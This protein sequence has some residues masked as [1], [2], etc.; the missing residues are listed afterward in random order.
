VPEG[1]HPVPEA[2]PAPGP[3]VDPVEGIVLPALLRAMADP[4]GEVRSAA[5]V[6]LG[7]IGSARAY[8]VLRAALTDAHPDVRD[9]AVLAMGLL[10]DEFGLDDFAGLLLDPAVRGRTRGFA[11]LAAGICGGDASADLLLRF[12]A[13]QSDSL[14]MGG[15]QRTPDLEACAV[16]GLGLTGSRRGVETLRR[17]LSGPNHEEVVRGAACTA[18][19]R[20]GDRDSLPHVLRA[21][22]HAEAAVRQSACLALGVLAVPEDEDVVRALVRAGTTDRDA[23]TRQ[24][25][26]VSLGKIGGPAA[27][28]ALRAALEQGDHCERPFAALALAAAGDRATAPLLRTLLRSS[29]AAGPRGAAAVAL[30]LLADGDALADLRGLAFGKADPALRIH[31]M[32]ALGL[33]ADAD[34]VPS[35]RAAL[36]DEPDPRIRLAAAVALSILQDEGAGPALARLAEKGES[37]AVRS[38]SAYFLGIVGGADAAPVLVRI[39]QDRTQPVLLR[40][41]AAAGLGV[42]ADRSPMPVLSALG[43]DGNFRLPIDPAQEVATFL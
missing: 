8:P 42:L 26:L 10:R 33:A 29:G 34:S 4:D 6:A 32:T 31:C 27:L 13:P 38:H 35:F 18:L 12:L 2:A 5:A 7:K 40:T 43:A 30:G 15:L 17:L 11:A 36:E 19:A 16:L 21:L 37:A 25:A 41:F 22:G 14:R 24:F 1:G 39:L 28:R 23:A 3:A 9:G 20:L